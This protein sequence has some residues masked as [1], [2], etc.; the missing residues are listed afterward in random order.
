LDLSNAMMAGII[1]RHEGNPRKALP[2]DTARLVPGKRF[3]TTRDPKELG[4]APASLQ[5][6]ARLT[7]EELSVERVLS[8]LT[9]KTAEAPAVGDREAAAAVATAELL[10]WA[11][12]V[13]GADSAT[14][15]H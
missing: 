3:E 6:V 1:L 7:S 9:D 10:G 4:R 14:T 12:L 11:R 8:V 13:S 5:R 15:A 2:A